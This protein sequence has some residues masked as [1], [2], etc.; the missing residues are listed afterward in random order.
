MGLTEKRQITP[1]V[2]FNLL[3]GTS[4]PQQDVI[5][6]I[7]KPVVVQRV[8][9]KE[10]TLDQKI[11][12]NFYK[13]NTD[14]QWIRADNAQCLD[15]QPTVAQKPVKTAVRASNGGNGYEYLS[16]TWWVKQW[17]P[18]VGNWGDAKNWGYAAQAEGWSVSDVPVV[19]AVAWSTRGEYGH[20]GLVVGVDGSN[21]ILQEGNYDWNGSIRTVSVSTGVYKYIY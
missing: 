1:D 15:K 21:I 17:K 11:K 10:L 4:V 19:G 14:I 7:N 5:N 16:C 6:I 8:E 13:C 18:E 2:M 20:V 12:S 9:E 3:T